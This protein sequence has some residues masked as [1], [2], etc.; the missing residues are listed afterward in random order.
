MK[1]A[2]LLSYNARGGGRILTGFTPQ[3]ILSHSVAGGKKPE[4]LSIVCAR[5]R[6]CPSVSAHSATTFTT[7]GNFPVVVSPVPPDNKGGG[8]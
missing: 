2:K 4:P 7:T 1:Q 6:N 5:V 8:Q 3:G